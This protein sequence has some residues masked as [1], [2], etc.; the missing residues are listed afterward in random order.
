MLD[1]AGTR[2]VVAVEGNGNSTWSFVALAVADRGATG[3][4]PGRLDT[5]WGEIVTR[6]PASRHTGLST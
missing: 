5:T 4:K 1:P 3:I 2:L 6:E